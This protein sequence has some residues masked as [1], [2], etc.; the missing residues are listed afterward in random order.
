MNAE[1]EKLIGKSAYTPTDNGT[2]KC[3]IP[4]NLKMEK[5]IKEEN[6]EA[7]LNP[8]LKESP[9]IHASEAPRTALILFAC[10]FCSYKT[11]YPEVVI[12]HK[13]LTH[14]DKSDGT[15]KNGYGGSLKQKRST[16]CPPALDGKDVTPLLMIDGRFPR[17]TKSPTPQPAQPRGKTPTNPPHGPRRSQINPPVHETQRYRQNFD[18]HASQETSMFPELMMKPNM[19]SKYVMDRPAPLDRMG[20]GKSCYLT[21]G[22][23]NWPSDA[24][25]LCLSSRFGSLPQM[26][27]RE[28]P[29]KMLKYSLSTGREADTSEKSGFR[30]PAGDGSNRLLISGVKTTSQRSC[31][32][33]M[34]EA[35]V[36]L[37]TTSPPIGGSLDADWSMMNLLHPYA[38]NDLT[39]LYRSTS[40][41]VSHGGLANTRA[42]M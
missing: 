22:G 21:R 38:P 25:R 7:P 42:G 11:I 6:S 8:S 26:D 30:R 41:A 35:L 13:R 16:G 37:K 34:P 1:Y 15:K 14:K 39:S 3:P 27:F 18:Q 28:P 33:P 4:V 12:I 32:S 20:I 2:I 10:S 40:A 36:P 31:Q 9:S 29:N 17:R 19:G 23:F 5:E 24:A